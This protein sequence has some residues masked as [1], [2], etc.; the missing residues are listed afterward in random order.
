MNVNLLQLGTGALG[1]GLIVP[2][3]SAPDN[4]TVYLANRNN[5]SS[6]SKNNLLNAKRHYYLRTVGYDTAIRFAEFIYFNEIGRLTSIACED[7]PVLLT[8]ALK[9]YGVK[10][11]LQLISRL[12]HAR[13]TSGI[14]KPLVFIACENA[15]SSNSIKQ[16]VVEILQEEY[17]TQYKLN[18]N[19]IFVDCVVDRIC[20]VPFV[21]SKDNVICKAEEYLSWT[22]DSRPLE[23][24]S[25]TEIVSILKA[26]D[27]IELVSDLDFYI[28]RKKWLVNSIHQ[29]IAL[30]SHATGYYKI[31]SFLRAD[32]G[33][34]ILHS[35]CNEMY[36][37]Y[38]HN[39]PHA[40]PKETKRFIRILKNRLQN[41]SSNV[42]SALTRFT[43]EDK[44]PDFFR[45]FYRKVGEPTLKFMQETSKRMFFV[46]FILIKVTELISKKNFVILSDSEI[47]T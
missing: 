36:E 19:I 4:T 43:H 14:S 34:K 2:K 9:E 42:Y 38:T 30:Y 39:E 25:C 15:I 3:F 31:D 11:S 20:N 7:K 10:N 46:P 24:E 32:G 41:N 47:N 16:G 22:I 13:N 8:T 45:D 5:E 27:G 44:L 40:N 12:I 1:L 37:I 33:D 35:V 28:R 21:D 26:I 17:G 23:C 18:E 29:I 6:E